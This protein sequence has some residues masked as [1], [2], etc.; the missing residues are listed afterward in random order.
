MSSL[1]LCLAASTSWWM[2]SESSQA[3][4]S[5]ACGIILKGEFAL[6]V[7]LSLAQ[8]VLREYMSPS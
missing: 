2:Q 6:E 7:Q 1:G 4:S 3:S 8:I 5:N